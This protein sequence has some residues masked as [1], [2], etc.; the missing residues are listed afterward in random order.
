MLIFL[1]SFYL[2]KRARKRLFIRLLSVFG[3]S[4]IRYSYQTNNI[5]MYGRCG[6]PF[7]VGV[8]SVPGRQWTY[9]SVWSWC[10]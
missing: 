5:Y 2:F 4:L 1:K 10:I 3:S 9:W 8:A 6:R 7:F